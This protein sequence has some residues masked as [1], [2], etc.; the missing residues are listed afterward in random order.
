[1]TRSEQQRGGVAGIG[2][3]TACT[4]IAFLIILI[5]AINAAP[6]SPQWTFTTAIYVH[7]NG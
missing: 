6:P 7:R 5:P 2:A 3:R 4:V 1:M